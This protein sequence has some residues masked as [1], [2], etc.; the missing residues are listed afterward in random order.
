VF[1]PV[2]V[3][4]SNGRVGI[5]SVVTK[6]AGEPLHLN[7]VNIAFFAIEKQG[8]NLSNRFRKSWYALRNTSFV[9]GFVDLGDYIL[10]DEIDEKH[11]DELGYALSEIIDTGVP[12]VIFCAEP[13]I[14]NQVV[15]RAHGYLKTDYK[16]LEINNRVAGSDTFGHT[17]SDDWL[18]KALQ[19]D[20]SYLRQYGLLG[21]QAFY[22]G[23]HQLDYLHK[24]GFESE[25]LGAL[26][27]SLIEAE[28]A[29][30]ATNYLHF[31]H[32]AIQASFTGNAH[33]YPNGFTGEEACALMRYG[34]AS[35]GLKVAIIESPELGQHDVSAELYA[36][37]L[38]YFCEGVNLRYEENPLQEDGNFTKYITSLDKPADNII[39]YKSQRTDRWWM[40]LPFDGDAY[41]DEQRLVP[42]SYAD[43]ERAV[44]GEIPNRWLFAINRLN[45]VD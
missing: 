33:Q 19:N 28:P 10:P 9:E 23:D 3:N 30:R 34:G 16:A 24:L 2:S 20:K 35:Q 15:Q 39:F 17:Q 5:G 12:V 7:H 27:K 14:A 38:W 44:A 6:N 36:Q 13:G 11:I 29:I 43:Y 32:E 42:C 8:P 41:Q 18:T 45:G 26:K 25:R 21:Y 40:Y 22:M 31:N 1:F 4:D 37:M